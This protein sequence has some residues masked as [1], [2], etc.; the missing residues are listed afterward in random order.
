[1]AWK[2]YGTIRDCEI[3]LNGV[4]IEIAI[5]KPY[6]LGASWAPSFFSSY[7]AA[8]GM[9]SG[10]KSINADDDPQYDEWP[11]YQAVLGLTPLG[12]Q[13]NDVYL[14]DHF[15]HVGDIISY[16]NQ[17]VIGSIC[18]LDIRYSGDQTSGGYTWQTIQW[19]FVWNGRE[20]PWSGSIIAHGKDAYGRTR[21]FQWGVAIDTD[22][23]AAMIHYYSAA[24]TDDYDQ[25]S[26]I[27]VSYA[28]S[29]ARS[30]FNERKYGFYPLFS[31]A[32]DPPSDDPYKEGGFS[33][34]QTPDGSYDDESD[35]IDLPSVPALNLSLNH[36]ISAY[37]PSA[38]QLDDLADFLWGD[39]SGVDRHIAKFF[40]DPT[41]AIISL[42]MLP[43][44]PSSSSAIEVTIG[45]YGSSVMMDPL[46]AQFKD[47][48]CGSVTILPYWD[49]Y[50]DYNPYTRITLALPYVGEVQLDPDEVM[51]QTVSVLYRV[52]CLSGAFV[53]F[54]KTADK[55]LAQYMGSC[56]LTVP[57]SS[58]SY[59]QANAAILGAA[60]A[61]VGAAAG[62]ATGGGAAVLADAGGIA[63]TALNV[64]NAK[65]NHSHSG[66]LGG[67]AGFLARQKPYLLIH[68]ARQCV[69]E[70]ANVFGGYPCHVTMDVADLEGYTVIS[71]VILDDLPFTKA[72]LDDLRGIL[73]SGIYV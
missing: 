53:C 63:S 59:S 68:R 35:E 49:N 17:N 24:L 56:V 29:M 39:Y 60:M 10:Y 40:A 20:D 21:R 62:V 16:T 32:W 57:I 42:H 71:S 18:R 3:R 6:G 70:D 58:A 25:Q 30:D 55:I 28:N 9:V 15:E 23:A 54:V 2:V 45:R 73:A 22:S 36:F 5:L 52:D 61:A 31:G 65:V 26:A 11:E 13:C 47:I 19:R 67:T 8:T 44:T 38:Q 14:F 69:P 12:S 27:C 64:S 4:L 1:M 7:A 41:D 66:A 72:E 43:F 37:V 33:E 48:D 46:T 51:G 50:L 34:T